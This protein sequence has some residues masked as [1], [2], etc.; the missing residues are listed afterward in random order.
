MWLAT[1]SSAHELCSI[2]GKF[3]KQQEKISYEF[4]Q[5]YFCILSFPK[6]VFVL[7]L[8][9]N[10][11]V[12]VAFYSHVCASGRGRRT[13]EPSSLRTDSQKLM[14]RAQATSRLQTV[15]W[16]LQYFKMIWASCQKI[17]SQEIFMKKEIRI[18]AF[19]ERSW[20]YG[21]W[22]GWWLSVYHNPG[23]HLECTISFWELEKGTAS[24]QMDCKV[25]HHAPGDSFASTAATTLNHLTHVWAL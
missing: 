6:K 8:K 11:I 5:G 20:S 16:F 7:F 4:W 22:G 25:P 24:G 15:D 18:L 9:A 12:L 14:V 2:N 17:K 19:L 1:I 21:N 10:P 23:W 13:Q 3:S